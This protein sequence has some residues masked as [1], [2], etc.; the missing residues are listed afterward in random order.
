MSNK[1][2][3]Y[4]G[5]VNDVEHYLLQIGAICK[6][7][8]KTKKGW[9]LNGEIIN[10]EPPENPVWFAF[11]KLR[12][13]TK[14][15]FISVSEFREK[16][17]LSEN[18]IKDKGAARSAIWIHC[19]V[20]TERLIEVINWMQNISNTSNAEAAATGL[21]SSLSKKATV[22]KKKGSLPKKS[23]SDYA[24]QQLSNANTEAI[25]DQ[26]EKKFN[27]DEKSLHLNWRAITKKNIQEY[28]YK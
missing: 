4:G 23:D 12:K 26:I 7:Q 21:D 3:K 15:G 14:N 25:L 17:G 6:T 9:G 11:N 5:V 10:L 8:Q 22:I 16:F 20:G 24:I 18:E 28:W 2:G 13:L 19:S 27:A 1:N